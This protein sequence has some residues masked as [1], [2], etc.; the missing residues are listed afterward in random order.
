MNDELNDFQLID[1]NQIIE[2]V[3]D[4][5]SEND[6]FKELTEIMEDEKFM[7][8][9]TKYMGSWLDIKSSVIYMK[10]YNEFKEKYESL[11][12]EQ[13]DKNLIVYLLTKVMRDRDLRPFTIK[14]MDDM[15]EGK[16]V[17]FFKEFEKILKSKNKLLKDK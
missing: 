3:P 12:D 1:Q 11:N 10:M 4:I 13:L 7:R 14:A 17:K 6:F 5:I 16:K 9:F 8:F 15:L 2:T